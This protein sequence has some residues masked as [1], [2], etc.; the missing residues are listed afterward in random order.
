MA[1]LTGNLSER[2]IDKVTQFIPLGFILLF[3]SFSFLPRVQLNENLIYTFWGITA[4]LVLFYL[5]VLFGILKNKVSPSIRFVPRPSHYVQAVVHFGVY[6]YW[7]AFVSQVFFQMPLIFAQIVFLYALDVLMSWARGREWRFGFGMFPIIFSTNLFL[8]FKDD[9]FYL[10]FAMVT[11]GA[12]AKEFITWN[13]EGRRTHIFNPSAFSLSVASLLLIATNNTDIS[14]GQAIAETI[15]YPEH[16]FL[17]IFLLSLVV[18]Y[19]FKVTLVTLSAAVTLFLVALF[20]YKTTGVYFFITSDVPVA[21]FLGLHLLVTDPST[22][23]RTNFGRIMFGTMYGISVLILFALLDHVGTP[24]FYDKLLAV[25]LLNLTIQYLDRFARAIN[26]SSMWPSTL[27]FSLSSQQLNL[28]HMGIW[29]VFFMSIYF[30]HTFGS[31]HPGRSSAYW[32]QACDKKLRNACRNLHHLL[33]IGC[34]NKG[35]PLACGKLA[36][37]KRNGIGTIRDDKKAFE[38]INY[39]CD[40]GITEACKRIDSGEFNYTK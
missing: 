38:L 9:V 3:F 11:V 1:T 15:A 36:W 5:L 13:K 22:S 12:L 23:P 8:W 30:T 7:G 17:C 29:I 2:N 24:T 35:E 19:L 25:P 37:M 4:A 21:V 34:I 10:Q 27:R 16:M 32:E 33:S 20:Y 18:Q 40:N 39:A 6:G 28:V 14:W 26:F 31:S